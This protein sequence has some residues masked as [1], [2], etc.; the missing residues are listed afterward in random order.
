MVYLWL[1][2]FKLPLSVNIPFVGSWYVLCTLTVKCWKRNLWLAKHL[3]QVLQVFIVWRTLHNNVISFIYMSLQFIANGSTEVQMPC[4]HV[5][6]M[7]NHIILLS[8]HSKSSHNSARGT[9]ITPS[10]VTCVRRDG[11]R[12]ELRE[13]C[14]RFLA[15]GQLTPQSKQQENVHKKQIEAG[16]NFT[17]RNHN[18]L[19]SHVFRAWRW[20]LW[21]LCSQEV[22]KLWRLSVCCVYLQVLHQTL[23]NLH[24]KFIVQK[25]HAKI[26]IKHPPNT[27]LS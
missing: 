14:A 1:I 7:I 13:T 25:I 10:S 9:V 23:Q 18:T 19:K 20:L 17:S 5:L 2:V 26:T 24:K 22:F 3:L 8:H 6:I 15:L 11:V 12:D 21:H 27:Y 16:F 4:H